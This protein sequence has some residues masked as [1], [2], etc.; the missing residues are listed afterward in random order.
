MEL[1]LDY[2]LVIRIKFNETIEWS[3][4]SCLI[5]DRWSQPIFLSIFLWI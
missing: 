3:K 5:T 1:N 2:F 4:Y